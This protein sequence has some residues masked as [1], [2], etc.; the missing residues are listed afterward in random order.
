MRRQVPLRCA[1]VRFVHARCGISPISEPPVG[2]TVPLL[3]AEDDAGLA[4][5]IRENRPA[6]VCGIAARLPAS[7][8]GHMAGDSVNLLPRLRALCGEQQVTVRLPREEAPESG[9]GPLFGDAR[10]RVPYGDAAQ[11]RLAAVLDELEA[12]DGRPGCYVGGLPLD[13]ELPELARELLPLSDLL[14]SHTIKAPLGPPVPGVPA[15]YLGAGM[16]RTPLHFDPTEN[17]TVVL[18]GS[19]RFLLFPP[20]ASSHLQPRGGL[21]AALSCRMHGTVPAVY[22]DLDVWPLTQTDATVVGPRP[23]DV[24]VTAGDLLYLP[25]AWW[26]AVGGSEAPNISVV[27]GHAPCPSKGAVYFKRWFSWPSGR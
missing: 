27:F 1:L 2:A 24:V 12:E 13:R 5:A 3:D 9:G 20:S 15:L 25:A 26:H 21:L 16:Q 11:G 6:V 22:S 17:L 18:Q 4:R 8:F 23:L 7:A 19:K 10:R 14:R